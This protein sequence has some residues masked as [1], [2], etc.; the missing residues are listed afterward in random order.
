MVNWLLVSEEES[1]RAFEDDALI[2]NFESESEEIAYEKLDAFLIMAIKRACTDVLGQD[3]EDHVYHLEDWW[4]NHTRYL[5]VSA[6]YCSCDLIVK[7]HSLLTEEFSLYRIQLVV[8]S[9]LTVEGSPEIGAMTIYSDRIVVEKSV[10]D[11]LDF[12]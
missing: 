5:S 12:K 7:L 3:A 8:D 1:D 10:S 9:N 6:D 4:P 2:A 11:R